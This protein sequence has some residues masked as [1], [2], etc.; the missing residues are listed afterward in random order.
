MIRMLLALSVS[1]GMLFA[2]GRVAP[3]NLNPRILAVVPMIGSGT[4]AD[5]RRPM[6]VPTPSEI[7]ATIPTVP[8]AADSSS[9]PPPV[10]PRTGIIAFQFQLSDDGKNAI[11]ELVGA[12]RNALA[13]IFAAAATQPQ[14]IMFD[15]N[16]ATNAQMEAVFQQYKK[17]FSFKTFVPLRSN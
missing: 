17:N 1:A 4:P 10:P 3:E 13:P 12:D 8:P 14:I 2:Q 9:G 15:R 5:P 7:A 16:Q 11:V 6:F